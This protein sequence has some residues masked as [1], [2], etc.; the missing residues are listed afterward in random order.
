MKYTI[1]QCHLV[2]SFF[3]FVLLIVSTGN[4]AGFVVVDN[5]WLKERLRRISRL[6]DLGGVLTGYLTV[7]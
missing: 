6:S 2:F 4:I 5:Y 7:N 1:L 3:L